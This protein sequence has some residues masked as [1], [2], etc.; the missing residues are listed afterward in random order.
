MVSGDL[1]GL[2]GG[3]YH[4]GLA[5][6]ALRL[7]RKG[8]FRGNLARA[9]SNG[10]AA[11]APVTIICTGTYWRNSWKYQ[12]RT[13][14]HFGWDNGT[15]LANMLAV[16]AASGLLAEIML[17][18]VD[19]EVNRLLDVDT[20]NLGPVRLWPPHLINRLL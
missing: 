17:G 19:S 11:H 16:S 8:D 13:Y 14:R 6:F 5:D 9:T 7:L 3:V 20:R 2:P 15:L 1:S 10:Q 12:A 18:F 4:F